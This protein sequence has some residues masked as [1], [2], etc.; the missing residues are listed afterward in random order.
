MRLNPFAFPSDTTFR[1]LLFIVA[2]VGVSLLAFDWI[3]GEFA[4]LGAEARALLSC[5]HDAQP[6][7][8]QLPSDSQQAALLACTTAVNAPRRAAVMLG[9]A[10]L[11]VGGGVAYGVAVALLRRRYR[12]LARDEAPQLSETIGSLAREIGV[13]TSPRLRWQPLDRR[14]LGLAFG[15][16]GGRELA[17]T[18]GLVPL[19][20][21]DR[22]AFRAIVLHELAHLRNGD[23]DLSYYAIGL[24]RALLVVAMLPFSLALLRALPSDPGT[25]LSFAWRFAA[26]LPL[27]YLIRSGI[28]R[29][30]EH[31]A[32]VRASTHEPEIRRVL[33]SSVERAR[34]TLPGVSS[35]RRLTAWHPSPA[36]RVAV[37]EDPSPLLRLGVLD[38]FGVGIVGTLAYEEVAT[39]VGY[40]G[41]DP[42]AVRGLSGLAFGPL[43]GIIVA[44][45]TWRQTFAFLATGRDRVRVVPIGLALVAGLLVGQRLSLATAISDDAVLLRPDVAPFHIALTVLVAIG[46]ILF[47]A[48]LTVT[49]RLWL[50]VATRLR[51]PAWASVP[52]AA[53]AAALMTVAIGMF[54]ILVSSREAV[55]IAVSAPFDL[56]VTVS[57]VVPV[58][59]P[60]WLWRLV[61]APE[62]RVIIEEPL[63]VAFFLVLVL[64]PWF[65]APFYARIP[66]RPVAPW[67]S[68]DPGGTLPEIERPALNGRWAIGIGV[69]A[70][71]G[72]GVGLVILQASLH[73][74]FDAPTRDR[75]EFLIAFGFW[76]ICVTLGGQVIAGAAGA[77]VAPR[78]ATLHGVLAGLVAGLAGTLADAIVRTASGCVPAM[79]I[80][81]GR[82]CGRPPSAEYLHT[83]LTTVLTIGIVGAALAAAIVAGMRAVLGAARTP[84]RPTRE[85]A[86]PLPPPPP[87]SR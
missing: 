10:V 51:S 45:G 84:G 72:V 27:V 41:V 74:R 1:F 17:F 13:S 66:A 47:V 32:D 69:A 3:Y 20:V 53:G 7:P 60:E 2:I 30:R 16:P 37:I 78:F 14:A 83:Y 36:R 58:V 8:G 11:L 85:P 52:V 39:L 40:F 49:S 61:M 34:S 48:W 18:G 73:A 46:A 62:V 24:W 86:L 50:P 33:A 57:R 25:T 87:P 12:P 76:L 67:G 26:L 23:V 54:E 22:P 80:V 43:V 35:W 42:L 19:S 79:D 77:A 21:R 71:I 68:L 5:L 6:A 81:V 75:D 4:D 82:P 55:E 63:V 56:Y 44:L 65:A 70:A 29:A 64:V 15:R 31:D 28:L 59:G 38:A 9:V